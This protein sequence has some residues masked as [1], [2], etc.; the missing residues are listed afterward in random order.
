MAKKKNPFVFLDVSIDGGPAEKIVIELFSD[1]VPKTAENFR[2]LCTGEKGIGVSTGKQLHY[3]GSIFHRIIK[4]FMAQAG[5]FSKRDG[6][7]GESIYGGKFADENFKRIHD[8]PG[9]L[10]MANA[11]RDTNGS[12]FFI[13]FKAARHLDGKHVVFGKVVQGMDI[14]REIEQVG[15]DQGKPACPVK[16]VDCGEFSES[17]THDAVRTEKDKKVKKSGKAF[18][19][20]DS[21]DGK[22][23]GRHKKSL[24]DKRKKRKR[25]YSSS[26]SY[27][28]TETETDSD[29]Y[30][31]SD[32]DSDSSPSDSSSSDGR[33][34]KRKK[35]SKKHNHG[36]KRKDRLREKRRKRRDK[37]S[38]R[39]TK[40]S[41][42]SSSDSESESS[43]SSGNEADRRVSAR[44]TIKHL[45]HAENKLPQDLGVGK[46]TPPP[47]LG[48]EA[49]RDREQYDELKA[50]K[51][52]SSHG[53]G[54]ASLENA[55]LPKN[56][57]K[58]EVESYIN[59]NEHPD[60]INHS[61]KS[62]SRS[63]K[64]SGSMSSKRSP[65]KSPRLQSISPA[66][67]SSMQNHTSNSGSP[68]RKSPEPSASKHRSL[69]RSKSPDG[70]PKRIRRGRGF[71]ERYSY[72]RRYRTP[73]PE[74]S[75]PRYHYGGANVQDRNRDRY[76]N[77][78]SYPERQRS[79]PKRHRSPPRGRSPPRYRGRSRS[80]SISRSPIGYRRRDKD[81]S[82][83]GGR[84]AISEKLRSRLGP[85]VEETHPSEKRRSRSRSLS[86][87]PSVDVGKR[88]HRAEKVN[89]RSTSRSRSRS[90]ARNRS[91]VSYGDL[92][93]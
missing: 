26:D 61:S 37:S 73:S 52:D 90:P 53:E 81:Q 35:T 12:Q 88:R 28:S 10:S 18:S 27:S 49:N 65:R 9:L 33:R 50:I 86:K 23:K 91:L 3:K 21:S 58:T 32:S 48:K 13:T 56:E 66:R 92:S 51:E 57:H 78:K 55:K 80:R 54:E 64:S 62:R 40:R 76:P 41:S 75:P 46:Q 43:S 44:K 16:I 34:R 85:R 22:G 1:V 77:Y 6:T 2:A 47:V 7:G 89:S 74:R 24:K 14:V 5:D 29:S 8:E 36:K 30:S 82:P 42:E 31:S 4:G 45:S 19:S 39:K 72:A 59:A 68:T 67:Q 20:D 63:P 69:S 87:S 11:G 84:P 38:R 25:R 60:L 83:E 93:P 79:S 15:S 70:S 17:K 71:T